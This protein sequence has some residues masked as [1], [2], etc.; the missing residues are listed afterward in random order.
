V[1][2]AAVHGQAVPARA[3][4]HHR[5]RVRRAHDHHR[6]QAHQAPDLGHGPSSRSVPSLLD[7]VFAT[8]VVQFDSLCLRVAGVCL[9]L[10]IV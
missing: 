10:V 7:A 6:Q 3:R 5:R 4:P 1:P 2:A 8:R 9:N